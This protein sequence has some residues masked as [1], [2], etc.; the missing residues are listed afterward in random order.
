MMK[1]LTVFTIIILLSLILSPLA[2]NAGE[3]QKTPITHSG[4]FNKMKELLGVWEGKTDMGKGMESIKAT[5][6]LTSA[7]N[8]IVERL[9][10]GQP[11]EMITLYHDFKGRLSMTHYCS[12][13]NQPH[14]DLMN[15]GENTMMFVLSKKNP[16]LASV[17]ETHM[18]SLR[19]SFD[20]KDDITQT[21]TLYEKGKKKSEVVI[22]LVRTRV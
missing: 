16:N 11:H 3:Y 12:L 8:A 2:G 9:F 21:W 4:D 15:P 19:I 14:M 18:H 13:G 5:Y 6:E 20:D 17:K 10:V 7:G 22:K 1:K